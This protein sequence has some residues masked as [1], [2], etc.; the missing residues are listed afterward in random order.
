M[1]YKRRWSSK[2][3]CLCE[4]LTCGWRGGMQPSVGQQHARRKG[5]LVLAHR[6]IEYDYRRKQRKPATPEIPQ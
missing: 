5:H 6:T 4:C 2:V 1:G 3:I